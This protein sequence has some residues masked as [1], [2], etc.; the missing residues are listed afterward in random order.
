M[1][2]ILGLLTA[3]VLITIGWLRSRRH[4][5]REHPVIVRRFLHPGHAWM[6]ET[7]DGDV[8]VG[9]DDFAQ[10]VIGSI[11]EIRLP[12]LLKRVRQGGVAWQIVETLWRHP[13]RLKWFG[14]GADYPGIHSIC[15]DPRNRQRVTVGVSCGG[16]WVTTDGGQTWNCQADGMWAAYMPPEAKNDPNIQD[17]HRVVQCPA[18]PDAFWAQHHNGVF[19]T[20][21]GGDTWRSVAGTGSGLESTSKNFTAVLTAATLLASYLP[22]R[23]ASRIDPAKV[24]REE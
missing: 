4:Q 8:L 13:M 1:S 18:Q 20:V 15:V 16:V 14:G 12:R 23:R 9:I 3:I 22:A 11:E 6:R 17:P 2:V 19:R 7:E 10:N 21:D 5:E 24:L